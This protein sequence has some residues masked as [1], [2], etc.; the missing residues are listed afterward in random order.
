MKWKDDKMKPIEGEIGSDVQSE[1]KLGGGSPN[2]VSKKVMILPPIKDNSRK[3]I[4]GNHNFK[5]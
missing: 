2:T 1:I 5:F 3:S 4:D